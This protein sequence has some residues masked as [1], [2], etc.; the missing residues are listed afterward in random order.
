MDNGRDWRLALEMDRGGWF[1]LATQFA[2]PTRRTGVA[3]FEGRMR[4]LHPSGSG[5]GG[6]STPAVP[7]AAR[8]GGLRSWATIHGGRAHRGGLLGGC[9]EG[10]PAQA[11][12]GHGALIQQAQQLREGFAH[13]RNPREISWRHARTHRLQESTPLPFREHQPG[14]ARARLHALGWS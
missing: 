5:V 8:F 4:H 3:R 9:A 10:D 13:R 1:G 2:F 12:Q 7:L 11:R 14:K 6:G